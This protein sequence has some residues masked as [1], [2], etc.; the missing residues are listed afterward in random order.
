[1]QKLLI[2]FGIL[3]IIAGLLWPLISKM[4]F[5]RLPGDIVIEK[6]HFRFYFP[7]ATMILLS[8]A[9]SIILWIIRKF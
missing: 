2:A 5:G 1:M 6:Q 4:P 7:L 9:A 8:A 3:L